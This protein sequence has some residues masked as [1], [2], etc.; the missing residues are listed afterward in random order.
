MLGRIAEEAAARFG[1]R[2]VVSDP[3]G[4]LSY[5]DLAPAA[6]RAAAGL[7]SRG[8]G[9]GDVV[10]LTLRSGGD[11]LVA[12]TATHIVGAVVAG[13]STA[14][15]PTERAALVDL[16]RPALVVASPATVEGLPLRTDVAVVEPGGRCAELADSGSPSVTPPPDDDRPAAICFTSGTTGPPKAA[17]FRERHLRAVQRID[18]G[19]DAESTWGGGGPMLASTQF[20]HVGMTAK[21][22]WYLRTGATLHVMERWRADD[23]LRLVA[24]HR[25]PTIGVVAPQLALMLRSPLIDELD[26]SCVRAIIAGGAASPP[27]LVRAA[28]ERL[29][30]AYSIRYS[31]TE[32]GGVGLGTA[33][34]APDAEALTTIGRPRPGVE[35]RIC[36]E[37]DRPVPDGTVGELQIRSDAVMDGYWGDP[38]A[39]S[40]ALA[41]DG[42]LRTGDLARRDDTGCVVLSG[43]R[44]EMYVRGGYNVFPSEVEAALVGLPS[45]RDCVV[46]PRSDEV[47]GEVGVALVVPADP[48]APPG[49]EQLRSAL[50]GRL[51][52]HK[53]PEALELIDRVPLTAAQKVDRRAAADL[54]GDAT[55]GVQ[56]GTAG[57][58]GNG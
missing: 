29:G 54:L 2:A 30:A 51:A 34:D 50:E 22:P 25:M 20:A 15:T 49:L 57:A 43:R 48:S 42:W 19:P 47:M 32:S 53:L 26:L 3:E 36:D 31:S 46:V 21:F 13:V 38:E 52:R 33:F 37:A 35:A 17:L 5:A 4:E 39:T 8:I 28:R 12:A 24:R 14:A 11:W 40:A 7:R 1:D 58:D 16:V 41:G 10:A 9:E 27:S 18:L 6:G 55:G 44:S 45:V 23:A 56:R